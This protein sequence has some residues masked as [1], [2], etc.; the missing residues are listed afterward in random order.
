MCCSRARRASPLQMR[1]GGVTGCFQRGRADA[2]QE[3]GTVLRFGG[4]ARYIV[5]LHA[6]ILGRFYRQMTARFISM[7]H[8][9]IASSL[10]GFFSN[11][12]V[13]A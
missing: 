10:D 3:I 4:R 5:P 6:I 1:I 2:F 8:Y 11:C 13:R 9:E 12:A 7:L